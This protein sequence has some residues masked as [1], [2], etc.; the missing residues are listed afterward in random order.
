MS[1]FENFVQFLQGTMETPPSFGIFHI[2]C[3]VAVIAAAVLLSYFFRN[4]DDKLI[5]RILLGVWITLTVLEIYKQLVFSMSVTDGVAAW[6]YQWYSFPFQLCSTPLYVLPFIV[7]LKD[8]KIRDAFI[9]FFAGFAFFGGL[10]VMI[11]PNDVFTPMIGINI[12]TMVH[13]GAQVAIGIMLAVR[14]REKLVLRNLLGSFVIFLGFCAI[15]T[16]L[17]EVVYAA[18]QASGSGEVFNMFYFS[19][20]FDCHL[21]ILADV[22]KALKGVS[23]LFCDI[24]FPVI[25]VVGFCGVSALFFGIEKGITVLVRRLAPA[26]AKETEE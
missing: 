18:L 21:P 5:R 14:Y 19:R 1:V 2:C 20:H 12:Q 22:C 8:S 16:V 6:H 24:V 4:S 23:E 17:N 26:K 13:H 10:V 25:Y 15:A 9:I 11:Y 3:V 7:F